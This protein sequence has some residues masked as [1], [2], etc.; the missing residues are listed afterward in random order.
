MSWLDDTLASIAASG[1]GAQNFASAPRTDRERELDAWIKA[2]GLT[3]SYPGPDAASPGVRYAVGAESSLPAPFS[4]GGPIRGVPKPDEPFALGT[5]PMTAGGVPPSGSIPDMAAAQLANRLR[6]ANPALSSPTGPVGPRP[7]ISM[8]ANPA[9]WS[10]FGAPPSAG[11]AGVPQMAH[12]PAI[13]GLNSPM[14]GAPAGGAPFSIAGAPPSLAA[15]QQMTAPPPQG[16]PGPQMAQQP[17]VPGLVAPGAAP[18]VPAPGPTGGTPVVAQDDGEEDAPVKTATD[19]SSRNRAASAPS[20][21]P[22]D[23]PAPAVPAA[24]PGGIMAGLKGI[25]PDLIALGAGLSGHGWGASQELAAS[26]TKKEETLADQAVTANLPARAL[27]AKGVDPA[28]VAAAVRQPELL[29]ALIAENFGK[30]KYKLETIGKDEFGGET[31]AFVN[32]SDPTDQLSVDGRPIKAGASAL[33]AGTSNSAYLAKGVSAVNHDLSGDAYLQ[34]YSPE[35]QAAVKD[36]VAGLATPTGNPRKGWAENIQKIAKK[37]GSD[38]GIPVD[39]TTFAQRRTYRNE[40]AKNSPN[41]AGGQVKAFSQLLEHMSSLADNIEKQGNVNGMGLP[42]VAEAA[43]TIRQ[44]SSNTNAANAR[45]VES[46]AQSAA[47][48][49]GKLF[50]GSQGG[51]VHERELTRNRFGSKSSQPVSAA[52][53]ESTLELA[54]GGLRALEGRRDQILGDGLGPAFVGPKE[55]ARIDHIKEV[56]SRLKG[57]QPAAGAVRPGK[58]VW[59]PDKGLV[60]Q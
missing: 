23:I 20:G 36:Y 19:L 43:N 33:P 52:A 22:V 7:D 31:K 41:T 38:K 30:S 60:P 37:W 44:H 28:T 59:T 11:G 29:K 8:M 26:R 47:G 54:Q 24:Q 35:V 55:Q 50:S 5:D 48:E 53:L 45:A 57:E 21:V 14:G 12:Q 42:D 4:L 2:Q 17:S 32:Q 10:P 34:Q 13:A 15:A 40:L 56:I 39:D 18:G 51:G 3:G 1:E 58:Y 9:D 6:A 49:I 27:V 46:D 16:A 25:S